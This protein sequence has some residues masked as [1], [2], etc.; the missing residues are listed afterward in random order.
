M[1]ARGKAPRAGPI[2]QMVF[3]KRMVSGEAEGY[4][5]L[6]RTMHTAHQAKGLNYVSPGIAPGIEHR[7]YHQP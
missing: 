6:A 3:R 7:Q 2:F 4:N 5:P 1:P